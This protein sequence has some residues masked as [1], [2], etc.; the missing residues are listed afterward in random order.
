MR[1][2]LMAKIF[3]SG[4]DAASCIVVR[5]RATGARLL[6]RDQAMARDPINAHLKGN[7]A[8]VLAQV[9]RLGLELAPRAGTYDRHP[10]TSD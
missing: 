8:S 4:S 9:C 5:H 3:W 1:V 10:H 2:L 7:G 6:G